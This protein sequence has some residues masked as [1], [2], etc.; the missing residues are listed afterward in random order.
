M[1]VGTGYEPCPRAGTGS[2][3]DHNNHTQIVGLPVLGADPVADHAP[4]LERAGFEVTACD[5]TPDWRR[6]VTPMYQA[7]ANARPAL[8]AEMGEAACNPLHERGRP[9]AASA[10]V[11]A[12]RL[13]CRHAAVG[14]VTSHPTLRATLSA[15]REGRTAPKAGCN[16]VLVSFAGSSAQARAPLLQPPA[17]PGD[18]VSLSM[19]RQQAHPLLRSRQPSRRRASISTKHRRQQAPMRGLTT[20]KR[21]GSR[22]R[23]PRCSMSIPT[24]HKRDIRRCSDLGRRRRGRYLVPAPRLRRTD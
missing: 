10:A 24:L 16:D 1:S 12:P 11:S 13:H 6:R 14:Y 8:A 21:P 7:L 17:S 20:L 23:R 2:H 9:D 22:Q 15:S 5:E 3:P 18:G 4:L 19:R